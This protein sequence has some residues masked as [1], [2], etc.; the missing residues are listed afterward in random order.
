[1]SSPARKF[2]QPDSEDVA[3]RTCESTRHD[4]LTRS[5]DAARDEHTMT[6][7]AS[8]GSSAPRGVRLHA[9]PHFE[10]PRGALTVAELDGQLPFPVARVY[11]VHS[12][13]V[14]SIRGKHAHRTLH[15]MLIG[16]HGSCHVLADDGVHREE[17]LLDSPRQGLYLPPMIWSVQYE[18]SPQAV[19]LVLASAPYNPTD[20][21]HDYS[22]FQE[23]A[24]S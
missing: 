13:P 11:L 2:R 20:Y 1:M 7:A 9:V 15:Q 4:A 17:Y 23:A 14:G 5:R 21:I 8:R 12:V 6:V 22:E 19:L 3:I 24:R 10:D 18:F 16:L